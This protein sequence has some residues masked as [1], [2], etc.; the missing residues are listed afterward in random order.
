MAIIA[1]GLR[2]AKLR[3]QIRAHLGSLGFTRDKEGLLVAPNLDKEGYRALH[4]GQKAHRFGAETRFI[5]ARA[6]HLLPHFANGAEIDVNRITIRL[7]PIVQGTWQSDLFR[8]A[9]L[10]WSV[11]VSMGFGRRLRFLVWDAHAERLVGLLALG[12][13]VFNLRARDALVGWTALERESRLVHMLDGYVVGAVPPYNKLLGGKLVACLMRSREIVD[14]FRRRYAST[15]GVI[16]GE[17]RNAHLVAV[18]TSSAL[19]RS[20]IYNRLRLDGTSYLESIGYTGGYGHFHFPQTL[21][22]D[23]RSYLRYRKDPY[24][25]N[26]RFGSGPNWRFRAIRRTL[27]LLGLNPHLIKHGLPREVFI[28]RL[29]DNAIE[30]LSG[31]RKR[32]RYDSLRTVSEV[33]ELALDRWIRPRAARDDSYLHFMRADLNEF[34]EARVTKSVVTALGKRRGSGPR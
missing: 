20:S 10:L 27:H 23:I 16:S 5:E 9:T 3:R 2:E 7:I 22:D 33:A 19:G 15:E 31:K 24:A 18:T 28:G 30:I 25:S 1:L 8:L 29:A 34:F 26:N 12:D 6:Q 21:F 4:R 32:P 11:P 17:R 14:E 13:P